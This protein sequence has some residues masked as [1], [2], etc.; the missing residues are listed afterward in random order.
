MI[1]ADPIIMYEVHCPQCNS[2]I[3]LF[4]EDL[5]QPVQCEKCLIEFQAS[6]P[7]EEIGEVIYN[8]TG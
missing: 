4:R 7:S 8:R 3:I 6:L 5:D 2:Q 1:Y